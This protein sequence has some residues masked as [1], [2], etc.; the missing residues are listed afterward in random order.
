MLEA[1]GAIA[2]LAGKGLDAWI[3]HGNA[4][5]N[6]KYQ[7]QFAKEGIQWRVNDAKAAGIHP[8]AALGA[9]TTA[10]SSV[11]VGSNFGEAGQDISRAIQATQTNEQRQVGVS[12]QM[13]ALQIQRAGLENTLLASQIAK[14]NQAG[15]PPAS[16]AMSTRML[17]GQGNTPLNTSIEEKPMER[18]GTM[19]GSPDTE[20][21]AVAE[22]GFLKTN[23]GMMPV[24][25]KDAKDRLEDDTIGSVAWNL[26]N[27]IGPTVG[28]GQ[29]PPPRTKQMEKEGYVW[30]YH[31]LAQEYRP[32][33]RR[34]GGIVHW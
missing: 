2:G 11:S 26:R 34:L 6:I 20:A 17:D 27:R 3:S 14:M 19:P 8:L 32:M 22:R 4:K 33:K 21:G 31:P 15:Q 23:T 16:P 13:Q 10:L 7:K 24:Y 5:R 29:N 25:S 9:Q 1:V 28:I 12:K 30:V 18:Q